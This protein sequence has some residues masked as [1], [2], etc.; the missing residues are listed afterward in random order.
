MSPSLSIFINRLT[1]V[2]KQLDLPTYGGNYPELQLL[3][4]PLPHVLTHEKLS[5]LFPH[6]HKAVN[7][8]MLMGY[9]VGMFVCRPSQEIAIFNTLIRLA[10]AF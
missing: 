5:F 3:E 9:T 10:D 1:C 6:T 4:A 8:Q 7:L 2:C